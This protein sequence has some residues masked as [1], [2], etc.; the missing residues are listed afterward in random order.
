LGRHEETTAG[1]ALKKILPM[2]QGFEDSTKKKK[3]PTLGGRA[4]PR[5]RKGET[6]HSTSSRNYL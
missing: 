5:E 2:K 1:L 4:E 6:N 3:T